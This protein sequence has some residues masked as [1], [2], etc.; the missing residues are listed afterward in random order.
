MATTYGYNGDATDATTICDGCGEE[1]F[2][3]YRI[4][5]TG[6]SN[7]NSVFVDM[8]KPCIKEMAEKTLLITMGVDDGH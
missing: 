7:R 1:V 8:C 4:D 5:F 6:D 3:Y 2:E